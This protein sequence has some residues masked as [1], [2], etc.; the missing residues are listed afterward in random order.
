MGTPVNGFQTSQ[1]I[2]GY[3]KQYGAKLPRYAV[4]ATY[5]LWPA[6]TLGGMEK[7]VGKKPIAS[8]TFKSK[9]IILNQIDRKVDEYV[10]SL[11]K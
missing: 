7:L 9:E 5:S 1:P 2:Q 4:Y 8:A 3:L 10:A 6:G 11:K